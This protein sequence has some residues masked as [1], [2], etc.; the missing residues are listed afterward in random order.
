MGY[1]RHNAIVVT[2]GGY[3]EAQQKLKEAHQKAN[4]LFNPLVSPI[5]LGVSNGSASF[6]VA[7]DGSKEGWDTSNHYDTKRK[8][9]ADF[10]D[11]LAYEDG[12]N[13]VQ[14][15]DVAFDE[16]YQT[17]IDRT[18]QKGQLFIK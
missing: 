10:I 18:N 8:E 5:I 4:Q 11:Q 2:G 3:P 12:S 7:P 15:V 9:L 17:Q 6:F 16:E 13:C 1:I 14:F